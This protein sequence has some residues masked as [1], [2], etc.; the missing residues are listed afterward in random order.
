MQGVGAA[1]HGDGDLSAAAEAV[2]GGVSVGLNL[3][4]LN[5]FDGGDEVSDVNTGILGV[6]PV[7]RYHLVGFA[8]AICDNGETLPGDGERSV[9]AFGLTSTNTILNT[10]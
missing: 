10:R 9:R 5:G 8:D 3:E 4:L 6:D 2:L 7:E 1:L